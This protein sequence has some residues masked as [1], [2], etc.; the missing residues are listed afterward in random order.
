M[1]GCEYPADWLEAPPRLAVRK[2]IRPGGL[3]QWLSGVLC[4]DGLGSIPSR[5]TCGRRRVVA[6]S[7]SL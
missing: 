5:G 3:A 2:R 7:P 4:A 6:L 1:P